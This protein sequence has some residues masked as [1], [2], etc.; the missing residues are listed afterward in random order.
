MLLPMHRENGVWFNQP[1]GVVLALVAAVVAA[2]ALPPTQDLK[3]VVVSAKG[4]PIAAA[5]CTLKSVGLPAEGIGVT[6]DERGQFDFPGLEPGEYDLTCAAVGHL[7]ASQNG[8]EVTA[9][10]PAAL[11]VVLPEPEKLQ[12]SVEVHETA[13]PLATE[14]A[15]SASHVNSQQLNTLP[16]V[17]EQFMAALP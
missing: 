2:C 9:A 5:L 13:T 3:G 4:L 10:N 14:S 8:L 11:Q 15:A 17:K 7:P 12:Q 1:G 6:T 16:L